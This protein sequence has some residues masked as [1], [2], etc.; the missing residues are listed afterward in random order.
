MRNSLPSVSVVIEWENARLSELG[1]TRE[2]LKALATQL[3]EIGDRMNEPPELIVLHDGEAVDASLVRGFVEEAFGT[4]PS[5]SLRTETTEGDGY[6]AQ[7]NRGAELASRE[8]LLFLD[9]DVVPEPGWLSTLLGNFADPKVGVACGNTY[10]DAEDFASRAFALFWFFPLRSAAT[11]DATPVES[12]YFFANNVV[13][14][15]ELFLKYRF[16]QLP[17]MR[18]QCVQLA[19]RL[20]EDGHRIMIDRRA[21]VSHPPPNG[22]SHFVRRAL[23]EGHDAVVQDRLRGGGRFGYGLGTPWRFA[24]SVAR[25]AKRIGTHRKQV[26]LG[27]A[28]A[29]GAMGLAVGYYALCAVGEVMG[30]VSPETV[31]RRLAV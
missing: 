15:R 23:V 12:E 2:M 3:G 11:P 7:K 19:K 4:P 6:Y 13:F 14:R 1:R 30:R 26:G 9:S 8:L 5:I 31:R 17:M 20:R 22:V 28:G 18:G 29:A 24:S 16:P 21:Q 27:A 10:M 25:A